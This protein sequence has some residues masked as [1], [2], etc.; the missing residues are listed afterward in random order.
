MSVKQ[1]A[2]NTN[3]FVK[4]AM[5]A[6]VKILGINQDQIASDV[7]KLERP[8]IASF[9]DIIFAQIQ[10]MAFEMEHPSI[11]MH[12]EIA[13]CRDVVV[14]FAHKD[15]AGDTLDSEDIQFVELMFLS[16]LMIAEN[17]AHYNDD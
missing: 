13:M 15:N 5:D 4:R 14:I 11:S 6:A 8:T 16:F 12:S 1:D 7:S 3:L 9:M 10:Q 17:L 2:S